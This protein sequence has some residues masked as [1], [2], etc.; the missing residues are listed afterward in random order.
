MKIVLSILACC[1][2]SIGIAN[3]AD[4]VS[5]ISITPTVEQMAKFQDG[6]M[7]AVETYVG[8]KTMIAIEYKVEIYPADGEFGKNGAC[9]VL[10]FYRVIKS[11]DMLIPDDSEII[12][13]RFHE[14]RPLQ[15]TLNS[16]SVYI[17]RPSIINPHF[18][19][20]YKLLSEDTIILKLNASPKDYLNAKLAIDARKD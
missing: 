2:I 1:F 16:E 14:S 5:Q 6:N 15:I 8:A 20:D 3:A 17:I 11:N 4:E 9:T 12:F 10:H 7:L 18:R 19:G 13:M